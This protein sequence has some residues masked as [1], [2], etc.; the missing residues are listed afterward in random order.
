MVWDPKGRQGALITAFEMV[1]IPIVY[2]NGNL[3]L[4]EGARVWGMPAPAW[5]IQTLESSLDSG[6]LLSLYELFGVLN[7]RAELGNTLD[8]G[9]RQSVGMPVSGFT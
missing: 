2:H 6:E 9:P 5:V 8:A 1:G 7:D 4:A 3:V